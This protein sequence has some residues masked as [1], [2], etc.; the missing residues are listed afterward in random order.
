MNTMTLKA[1]QT[2][3]SAISGLLG[4]LLA[5]SASWAVAAKPDAMATQHQVDRAPTES[6]L[7][8]QM[9]TGETSTMTQLTSV[10][11][12]SD[13]KPTEWAF[14]ALKS[15][16]ERYGCIVGYPD[17][18]YRG[19]RA[20]TRYEFAAGLNACL[21]KI[22]ELIAAATADFVRK[23]DLETI[24]KL[25][26]EFAAELATLRGR[27][28]ALEVRTAT[29]EKQQFSTTTKL[30]GEAIFAVNDVFGE[31]VGDLNNTVFQTR[32]RLNL[33]TSFSGR[34]V[35]TT[36]L[37]ASNRSPIFVVGGPLSPFV[38]DRNGEQLG[39]AEGTL[40]SSVNEQG[41]NQVFLD[42]LDYAFPVSDRVSF[43][44]AAAGG[45]SQYYVPSTINPYFADFDGGNGSISAFSQESPIYRIGGGAG[46]SFSVAF[47]QGRKF[48]LT[49]G[50][51]ATNAENPVRGQGLFNGTFAALGQLTITPSDAFQLGLTYVHG[52]HT[53][54]TSI[55]NLGARNNLFVTGTLPANAIHT[56]LDVAAVTNSYGVQASF[57][58]SPKFVINA[59]GGFTDL[60]LLRN[61]GS[62]EIWYYGLGIAL[63]DLGK[64]GNLG[65]I[66]VGVEPYLGSVSANGFRLQDFGLRNSTSLHIEGFYKYQI[67]DRISITPGVIWITAPDQNSNNDDYVILTVRTTFS[68]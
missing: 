12:L 36:R 45:R 32:V 3:Y 67:N 16:V 11:Q 37:A 8:A 46:A 56:A 10:S 41:G 49:G 63:P 2:P 47:D 7:L 68:F 34:D 35:L 62:G 44:V 61:T 43:Y 53:P 66:M 13:V 51:L 60:T 31:Q 22:Q 14:Q 33:Q 57:K 65:G 1:L 38:L 50:Y 15:L 52:Y 18:T 17:K 58:L 59:F 42:R 20:L 6:M 5:S 4:V 26:E 40:A 21:D 19:N 48:V 27:V 9:D 24:K 23:E 39:T 29:L 30:S 55:F 25:Q 64:R 54:G 28:D